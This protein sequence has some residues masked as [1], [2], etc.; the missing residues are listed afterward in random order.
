M[1]IVFVLGALVA[2]IAATPA[3]AHEVGNE[4]CTPGFWKNH[5]DEWPISNS[6]LEEVYDVPDAFGLDNKTLLQALKFGGG[7]G[8]TGMARNLLRHSVAGLL[9]ILHPEV[10]YPLHERAVINRTNAALNSGSRAQIEA[11]KNEFQR[12]NSLGCPL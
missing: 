10:E 8:L 1:L 2:A 11:Q 9:N 7:E 5:P 3:A 6:T 12:F 4:G